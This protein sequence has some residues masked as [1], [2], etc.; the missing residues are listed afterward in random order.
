MKTRDIEP[1]TPTSQ[2]FGDFDISNIPAPTP[3]ETPQMKQPTIADVASLLSAPQQAGSA[4]TVDI[5]ETNKHNEPVARAASNLGPEW[6]RQDLPSYNLPYSFQ[7]AIFL[8]TMTLPVVSMIWAAQKNESFTLFLD[9]LDQCINVD[10]RDITPEDFTVIMYWIRDNSYPR[11]SMEV[12]YTTRYNNVV[13]VSTRKSN[14]TL[15]EIDM[16]REEVREWRDKGIVFP[17]MRDAELLHNAVDISEDK[18]WML[19]KAQYVEYIPSPGVTNYSDY[20]ER[21]LER[22]QEMIDLHGLEFIGWIDEFREKLDYGII[23]RVTIKDPKFDP[24]AAIEYFK[25]TA[26]EYYDLINEIPE[27]QIEPNSQYLL[28][29]A[30]KAQLL[31]REAAEIKERLEQGLPVVAK[32]EVVVVG[33]TMAD[34]F[35]RI[36]S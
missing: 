31:L 5:Q 1:S 6:V 33:I 28:L 20:V 34:F 16:T 36:R 30:R 15:R 23:E 7:S 3:I 4:K 25:A 14:M 19:E 17:T 10:I 18:K 8:R 32:E 2:K 27:D 21:K 22:L 24:E 35:P 13:K 26:K 12:E 11:S 29:Y 9:A